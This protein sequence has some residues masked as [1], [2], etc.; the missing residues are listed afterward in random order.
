MSKS[1]YFCATVIIFFIQVVRRD[2]EDSENRPTFTIV[3]SV[4]KPPCG[5]FKDHWVF[6]VSKMRCNDKTLR[7]ADKIG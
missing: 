2:F 4:G 7:E 1:L 6:I 3:A 5:V